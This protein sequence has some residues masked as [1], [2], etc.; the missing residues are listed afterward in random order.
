MTDALPIHL[1]FASTDPEVVN[2]RLGQI[3]PG[4][5]IRTPGDEPVFAFRQEVDGDADLALGR[6][7]FGGYGRARLVLE[8]RV[9]VARRR[10]GT[11]NWDVDGR[12]G[13]DLVVI[14]PQEDYR[15][16][17]EGLTIDSVNLSL[18]AL[19]ETAR[20][21]YGDERLQV[22]F[23]DPRP[24]SPG[25]ESYW[26]ATHD[27]VRQALTDPEIA[28][29]PLLR[30]DLLR[31]MAVATLEVFPLAGDPR[32]RRVSVAARQAGY[33]RAVEFLHAALSLPITLEDVARHAAM[34][35]IELT[36]TFRSHAGTT[37]GAYLRGLRLAAAHRDLL[38]GDPGAGDT[39]AAIAVRWGFAYPGDFARRHRAAYG[40]NPG[41]TLRH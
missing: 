23:D 4:V 38:R 15:A 36:R 3:Y 26:N 10:S 29:V 34:S 39:V 9:T 12:R 25:Q 2:D 1:R 7:Q 19:A 37:P 35:T 20:T 17:L 28:S 32:A 41:H 11:Y 5:D 40:E 30:A 21:V 33:T 14:Q 8:D 22:A 27:F 18:S 24:V 16:V 13:T 31:R 6:F